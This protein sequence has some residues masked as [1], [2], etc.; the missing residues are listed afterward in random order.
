MFY[1]R[2]PKHNNQL[3]IKQRTCQSKAGCWPQ[4]RLHQSPLEDESC[5]GVRD[6]DSSRWCMAE[7]QMTHLAKV[8]CSQGV[9]PCRH[10]NC[11]H[12]ITCLL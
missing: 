1:K 12:E 8:R 9:G 3:R 5:A 2:I 11:L 4:K 7:I 10:T 6:I